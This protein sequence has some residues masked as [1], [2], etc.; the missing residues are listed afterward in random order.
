MGFE[1]K[2][3]NTGTI[4]G[5]KKKRRVKENCWMQEGMNKWQAAKEVQMFPQENLSWHLMQS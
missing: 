1:N 3:V 4:D 5:P 2:Q